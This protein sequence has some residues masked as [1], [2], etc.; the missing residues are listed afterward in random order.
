MRGTQWYGTIS[1][2]Y[3]EIN[4]VYTPKKSK[5]ANNNNTSDS[6]AILFRY[7]VSLYVL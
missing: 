2:S 7:K 1:H 3:D 5:L 6:Q 4:Y